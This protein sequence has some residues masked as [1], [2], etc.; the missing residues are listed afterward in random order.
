MFEVFRYYGN[1]LLD[2]D[3][4]IQGDLKVNRIHPIKFQLDR[5]TQIK[6]RIPF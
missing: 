2:L 5:D 1:E 4:S 3:F 6:L